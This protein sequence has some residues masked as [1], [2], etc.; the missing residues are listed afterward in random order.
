MFTGNHT[1]TKAIEGRRDNDR[2]SLYASK[3]LLRKSNPVKAE[4]PLII[5]SIP[6]QTRVQGNE[7]ADNGRQFERDHK[8]ERRGHEGLAPLAGI[9]RMLTG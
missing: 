4:F 8:P 6:A 2:V 7:E 9:L 3:D 5:G 1:A